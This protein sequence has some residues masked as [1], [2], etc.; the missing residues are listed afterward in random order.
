MFVVDDSSEIAECLAFVLRKNGF[1]AIAFNSPAKALTAA[2]SLSP[3]LLLTDLTMPEMD[4]VTLA[5]KLNKLHP[6]CRILMLSGMVREPS[7]Y[8]DQD[9]FDWLEKPVT[10]RQLVAKVKESLGSEGSEKEQAS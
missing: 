2:A 8:P 10:I 6:S 5:R 4:G 3:D 9:N 1:E 7:V